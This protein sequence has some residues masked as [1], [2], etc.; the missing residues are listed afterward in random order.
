MSYA[1]HPPRTDVEVL[2]ACSELLQARFPP[3]W[4]AVAMREWPRADFNGLI[5]IRSNVA[6]DIRYVFE[7]KRTFKGRN[8]V[9]SVA[10]RLK[11]AALQEPNP[12][13]TLV[14][15]RY[16]PPT[17]REALEEEAVSFID[18]TGNLLVK[19]DRP[20]LYIRDRGADKDP[21]RGPGRP[22]QTLA[23]EPAARLVRTL[24]GAEGPWSARELVKASGASTGATYRVLDYLQRE[25]LVLKNGSEYSTPDWGRLLRSWSRDYSFFGT[26]RTYTYIE[27]RGIPKLLA[28]IAHS[29]Y[30][31]YAVT[32]SVAAVE[33]APYA[34][35]TAAMVYVRDAKD[36]AAAWGLRPAEKGGNIVLAEPGYDVVFKDKRRSEPGYMVAAPEQVAVDL[37]TGP[38]RNP[39]EGE[40]LIRWMQANESEWRRARSRSDNGSS[41]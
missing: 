6:D 28:K 36:A 22:R 25:G 35:A 38:G 10:K 17:V 19:A 24:V 16:L 30:S 5:T 41:A 7:V 21:W 23:G 11:A 4:R 40:E 8:D 37:L 34:P 32:G 26:N 15:S 9:A 33:W 1:P 2:D 20:A 14:M 31:S 3:A 12:A 18:A 27:P 13:G 39:S 29:E